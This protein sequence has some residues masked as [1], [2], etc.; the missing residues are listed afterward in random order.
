M[1]K[2]LAVGL[3]GI[4][5]CFGGI[6]L[7]QHMKKQD[8]SAIESESKKESLVQLKTEMTGIPIVVDGTVAGY[9]VFQI[10]S[11]VDSTVLPTKDFDV[12]PYLLDAAIRASYQSTE[13]GNLKFNAA[14]LTKLGDLILDHAN[15]K[16][17]AKVVI[18]VNVEQF[19]FVSKNEVRGNVL[20]GSHK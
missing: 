18:A 17:S 9:L 2:L 13:D 20:A 16:L 7:N 6:V 1:L 15:H 3:I 10:S 11:T 14:Y 4:A 12:T 19:N 8:H 5:A